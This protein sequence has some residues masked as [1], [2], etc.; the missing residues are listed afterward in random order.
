LPPP[1]KSTN[2][3]VKTFAVGYDAPQFSELNYAAETARAVGTDRNRASRN[4]HRPRDLFGALPRL[5]SREDE[6]IAWPASVSLY[7]VSKVASE[8]V[9]VVLTGEGSDELFAGDER[10]RWHSGTNG[11]PRRYRGFPYGLGRSIRKWIAGTRLLTLALRRKLGHTFLAHDDSFESLL[12]DNFYC[13]F[14]RQERVRLLLAPDSAYQHYLVHWIRGAGSSTLQRLLYAGQKT[15]I[16]SS[17]SWQDRMSMACSIEC[18]VPLLDHTLVEF[19]AAMPDRL[20][21]RGSKQHVLK[22]AVKDLL[23]RL[24]HPSPQKGYPHAASRLAARA[25]RRS[26]YFGHSNRAT[27]SS[28]LTSIAEQVDLLIERLRS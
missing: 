23:P 20:K 6:P 11:S 25:V 9:K 28:R 10:Y 17:C 19:A 18:R 1:E 13:A 3:P 5:I 8:H 27:A 26:R 21:T 12:L 24:C 14:L 2:C 7:F 4:D 22:K 16:S 15:Y